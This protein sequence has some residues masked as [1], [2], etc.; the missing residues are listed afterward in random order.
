MGFT[1]L[2]PYLN[3]DSTVLFLSIIL[4]TMMKFLKSGMMNFK[5]PNDSVAIYFSNVAVICFNYTWS[6]NYKTQCTK[7]QEQK[8]RVNI[9]VHFRKSFSLVSYV[10]SKNKCVNPVTLLSKQKSVWQSSLNHFPIKT[11]SKRDLPIGSKIG[12]P[13]W[14]P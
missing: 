2:T 1:P 10:N 4:Y 11:S 7:N 5:S 6:G 14:N 8:P 3:Y 12:Q 13:T 9:N